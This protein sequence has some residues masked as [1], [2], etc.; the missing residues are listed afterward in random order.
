MLYQMQLLKRGTAAE[1]VASLYEPSKHPNGG[2]FLALQAQQISEAFAWHL[3][4]VRQHHRCR[5]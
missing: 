4:D 1:G 3:P 2:V 5:Y